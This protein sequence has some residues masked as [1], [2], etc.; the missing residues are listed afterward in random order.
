MQ[1]LHEFERRAEV[2]RLKALNKIDALSESSDQQELGPEALVSEDGPAELSSSAVG[3]VTA[4]HQ[5]R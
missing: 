2:H 1:S 3:A 5:H 4:S